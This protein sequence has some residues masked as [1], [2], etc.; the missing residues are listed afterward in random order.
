M[1]HPPI[2]RDQDGHPIPQVWDEAAG[3]WRAATGE[4]TL[5]GSFVQLGSGH[6]SI[7]SWRTI[8]ASTSQSILVLDQPVVIQSI[9]L[10]IQSEG[11]VA[12]LIPEIKAADGAWEPITSY[13]SNVKVVLSDLDEYGNHFFEKSEADS[14]TRP[15]Y[16]IHRDLLPFACDFG[17]RIS[18]DNP[19][20]TDPVFLRYNAIY[21]EV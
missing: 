13:S 9:G 14:A 18:I 5:T 12:S 15:L 21:R 7:S 4:V 1:A 2:L 6:R 11:G 16:T 10:H 19:S 3:E 8:A 20:T 17:F